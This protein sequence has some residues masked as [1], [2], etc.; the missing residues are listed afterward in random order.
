MKYSNSTTSNSYCSPHP[1]LKPSYPP[2]EAPH[3]IE[4]VGER[5]WEKG[6]TGLLPASVDNLEVFECHVACCGK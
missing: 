2:N 5:A 6:D 1:T 3:N 4:R